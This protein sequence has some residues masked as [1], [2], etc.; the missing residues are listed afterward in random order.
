VNHRIIVKRMK[1]RNTLGILCNH[2]IPIKLKGKFYKI[3]IRAAMLYDIEYWLLRSIIFIKKS[4][5]R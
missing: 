4:V 1:W 5:L 3:V 2:R